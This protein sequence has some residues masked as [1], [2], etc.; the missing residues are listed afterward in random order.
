MC[1]QSHEPQE[2]NYGMPQLVH[3]QSECAL[4]TASH[5]Y[6]LGVHM[7]EHALLI[8]VMHK[9]WP[10]YSLCDEYITLVQAYLSQSQLTWDFMFFEFG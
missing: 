6:I 3:I 2:Y 5:D 9:L 7:N 4:G 8:N 1:V 10:Y